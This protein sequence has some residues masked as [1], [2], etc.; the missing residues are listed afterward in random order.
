M[1]ADKM[2][3]TTAQVMKMS[4]KGLIPADKAISALIEGMNK[5]FPD[6][7]EKQSHSLQGLWSTMKDTFNNKLLVQWGNGI[8]AALKPRFEQIVKWIDTNGD[9][10]DRW[11]KRIASA[12]QGAADWI[13]KKFEGAFTYVKS[14][15]L[16]NPDFTRIPDIEGKVQFIIGDLMGTFRAW[17]D[18]S[19]QSLLTDIATN[20]T[21]T[22]AAGI[23][24]SSGPI[25]TAAIDIGKSIG[26]GVAKGL[27]QMVASHPLLSLVLGAGTGALAG[28]R[29]GAVGAIA[30]AAA[31][32]LGTAA[33]GAG[34]LGGSGGGSSKKPYENLH[35]GANGTQSSGAL[36]PG[37]DGT[38]Y[39]N[40]ARFSSHAGGLSR[41]PYNGYPALLHKDERV[42][43]DGEASKRGNGGSVVVT[44]NTF[45]VRQE[46]DIDAI[47]D[48][49][50]RRLFT[51]AGGV[52]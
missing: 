43:T 48:A 41:V 49:L 17:Y 45:V 39:V 51:V 46:S 21:S 26:S 13:A 6:M 32:F 24:A 37:S 28:A 40:P 20:V 15:F 8:A 14:H 35:S 22:I 34:V 10:I 38:I 1:L 12:A 3:V 50:A 29:F 33:V 5:K 52:S 7:M 2:G 30:G 44:G 4:E 19:G 47:A 18:S 23:S 27:Q 25:T 36:L 11:G 31:G 9:A 16:N 42:L